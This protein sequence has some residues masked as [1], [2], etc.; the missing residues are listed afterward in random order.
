MT[1]CAEG[2]VQQDVYRQDERQCCGEVGD[3]IAGDTLYV[4]E[5]ERE[6]R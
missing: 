4:D 5:P 3:P 1:V 6:G 2:E